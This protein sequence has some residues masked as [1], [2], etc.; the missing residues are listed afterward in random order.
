MTYEI[1]FKPKSIKDIRKVPKTDL[2]YIFEKIEMM[3]TDLHG[4]VKKLTNFTPEYRLR[5]GNYR[6]LFEIENNKIIVYRIIHRKD[7]YK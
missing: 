5:T 1:E 6:I 2:E 4:D 3:K 7:A